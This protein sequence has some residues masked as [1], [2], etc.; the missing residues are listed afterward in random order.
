MSASQLHTKKRLV[1]SIM[2]VLGVPFTRSRTYINIIL[3]LNSIKILEQSKLYLYG[4]VSW[5][6]QR[7]KLYIQ[8]ISLSQVSII[9]SN[10]GCSNNKN[11]SQVFIF[12]FG[13]SIKFNFN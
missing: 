3:N 10:C 5:A 7:S 1:K 11:I 2:L 4:P 13:C 9:I 6:V 12:K 8:D